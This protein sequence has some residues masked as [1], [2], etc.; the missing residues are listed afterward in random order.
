MENPGRKSVPPLERIVTSRPYEIIGVDI[1]E[2]GQIT[3]GNSYAVTVIDNFSIYAA[4]YP[5]SD[6]SA[7]IVAKTIFSRL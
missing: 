7:V 1:F 6:K 2:L 3:N 5:V 4:A